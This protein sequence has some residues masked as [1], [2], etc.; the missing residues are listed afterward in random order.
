[1]QKYQYR[2]VVVTGAQFFPEKKPWPE[3][4]KAQECYCAG[5]PGVGG[6]CPNHNGYQRYILNIRQYGV[7]FVNP[8][9]WVVTLPKG[10]R[11]VL[12]HDEFVLEFEPVKGGGA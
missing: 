5:L 1:M 9:D 2:V 12:S 10:E 6:H 4:V 8:G 11:R 7:E 3:G